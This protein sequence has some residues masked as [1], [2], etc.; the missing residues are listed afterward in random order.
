MVL[1]MFIS[2]RRVP[3]YT[4]DRSSKSPVDGPTP[5]AEDRPL[6]SVDAPVDAPVSDIAPA[7]DTKS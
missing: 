3:V 5:R 6:P 2:R 7:A 1:D 4:F